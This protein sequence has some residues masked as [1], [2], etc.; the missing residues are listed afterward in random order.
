MLARI[1][2]WRTRLASGG[3]GFGLAALTQPQ[4]AT[5]AAMTAAVLPLHCRL[6]ASGAA[7]LS[8][9]QALTHGKS[10]A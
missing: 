5:S 10:L 2:L 3:A 4:N 6:F 1:R 8:I 9:Q 7:S